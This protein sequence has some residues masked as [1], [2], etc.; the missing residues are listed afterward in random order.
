MLVVILTFILSLFFVSTAWF[1]VFFPKY[2][3]ARI[4]EFFVSFPWI[5]IVLRIFLGVRLKIIGKKNVDRKRTTLYICNHQSWV[6]VPVL[7]RYSHAVG[8]SKKEIRRIPLV[9]VL[10]LYSGS[11]IIVDR[12]KKK[13]RLTSV[14]EIMRVLKNGFSIFLFPEGTR[15]RDGKI[16]KA[17]LA[18]TRLCY[19]LN[20]PVIPASIEGTRNILPRNRIYLKFLQKVILKFNSPI[21]PNDYHTDDEFADSCWKRVK[22]SHQEILKKYFPEKIVY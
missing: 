5:F 11:I 8:V 21:F 3:R 1:F 4:F 22:S 15:S 10:M 20:I 7:F 17:N 19:K 14:K 18:I 6:D 13:S 9:G 12:D 16:L 2:Y